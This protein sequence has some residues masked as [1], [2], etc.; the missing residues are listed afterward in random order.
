MESARLSYLTPQLIRKAKQ[1]VQDGGQDFTDLENLSHQWAGHVRTLLN[2]SQKANMPWSQL[3]GRLV[4]SARKRKGL[5][6]E[7]KCG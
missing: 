1:T 4:S 3:A 2:A 6:K 7:V 5:E